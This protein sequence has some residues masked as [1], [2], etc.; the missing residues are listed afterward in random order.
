MDTKTQDT[1]AVVIAKAWDSKS[2]KHE[3]LNDPEKAILECTGQ[4]VKLP[5]GKKLTV[6]WAYNTHNTIKYYF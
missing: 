2:F 3:L 5:A 4:K 6:S 1:T